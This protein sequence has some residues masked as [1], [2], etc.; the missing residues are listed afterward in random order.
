MLL[1]VRRASRSLRLQDSERTL[2]VHLQCRFGNRK[3][4]QRSAAEGT[5]RRSCASPADYGPIRKASMIVIGQTGDPGRH[6]SSR[7]P[8]R[9][10]AGPGTPL[11]D[12][13][14]PRTAA[15][16]LGQPTVEG[17]ARS[18]H[19]SIR[20]QR[21]RS[22]LSFV[23]TSSGGRQ[24][25]VSDEQSGN[26]P[27]VPVIVATILGQEGTTGVQTH[28]EQLRRYSEKSGV[29]TTLVTPFAWCRPLTVP[30]FGLRFLIERFSKSGSVAWYRRGHEVFLRNA[31]RRSLT[32]VGACCIYAQCP[33][34]ARA[35]LNARRGPD[36]RVVLA[37]H[38]RV[39][40]AD[41][42]VNKGQ[43]KRSGAVF[44]A[45]RK[46]ERDVIPRVDGLIYV[47]EWAKQALEGWL[48]EAAMVPST[49]V[50]NFVEPAKPEPT[51]QPIGDLITVGFL[52]PVKNHNYIL[53]VLAAANRAGRV[54]TLDI[55]GTG[56]LHRELVRRTE[57][58][59]LANQVRF[60]G[61]RS[62][63]R[64]FM[65]G[66]RTYVHASYSESSSLAII[67]AMAAGLPIVAARIGAIPEICDEG[68]E[69]RFWPLD[70]AATGA[71]TLLELLDCEPARSKAAAAASDRFRREFD[72]TVVAPRLLAFL[73]GSPELPP[74]DAVTEG[75]DA[76]QLVALRESTPAPVPRNGSE[77]AQARGAR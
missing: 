15:A 25:H 18:T 63:V 66:Y 46:L 57:E 58:L 53:E 41:E 35:A 50:G 64:D 12:A 16:D 24:S 3:G 73:G 44:R 71:S 77:A 29:A 47:S 23:M 75:S 39:S 34:A 54:L 36:Q 28:V 49:V 76:H 26:E 21:S 30:V 19:G 60:R 11:S 40:Q 9:G 7:W 32:E 4:G 22:A 51:Q 5:V 8:T 17:P 6:R 48:P 38:F 45:I 59:D 43:I 13:A 62:N 42:W 2:A 55:F 1:C 69:A 65:P 10:A 72:A 27:H 31:L 56:P 61:H 68:I 74:E 52:E 70:D 37:V 20:Y 67:E 14:S 33:I